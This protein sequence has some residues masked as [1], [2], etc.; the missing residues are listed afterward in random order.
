MW[1]VTSA[2]DG[3]IGYRLGEFETLE[4][5]TSA[6]EAITDKYGSVIVTKLS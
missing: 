2:N 5:L 6:L 3:G 4:S 1:I